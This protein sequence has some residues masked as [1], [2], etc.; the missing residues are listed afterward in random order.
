[1]S[2]PARFRSLDVEVIG[3]VTVASFRD[4]KILA[5]QNIQHIGEQLLSLA[6][7]A[8]GAKLLLN[9][10]NVEYMSSAMLGALVTLNKKVKA[11]K[12]KLVM[13]HIDPQIREVFTITDLE[14]LFVIRKDEQEGLQ[15][16]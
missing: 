16:F 5:E 15:A 8:S 1:M 10:R 4:R 3:D 14:K 7:Q 6:D 11:A 9:F 2:S 12:G 13:C